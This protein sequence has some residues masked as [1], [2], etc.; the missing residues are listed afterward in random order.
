MKNANETR[1][2]PFEVITPEDL[3]IDDMND[4]FVDDLDEFKMLLNIGHMMLKGPRGVG[5]SMMFRYMQ[6]DCMCSGST[7]FSELEFLGFRIP[8]KNVS[9]PRLTEIQRLGNSYAAELIEEH[10]LVLSFAQIIFTELLE[11]KTIDSVLNNVDAESLY[12]Y[13]IKVFL[14]FFSEGNEQYN[15][16]HTFCGI[17]TAINE[18]LKTE[19]R[20]AANYVKRLAMPNSLNLEYTGSFLNYLEF[21]Y[22]LLRDLKTI[23]G[24]PESPVYLMIDDAH[25]LTL[26]QTQILNSWMAT[27]TAQKISIKIST[28]YSYKTYYTVTGGTIDTPHDYKQIDM[29]DIYTANAR[30]GSYRILVTKVLSKRFNKYNF[31]DV[32]PEVFFPPNYEQENKIKE[33]HDRYI[34]NYHGGEGH[35]ARPS[36]DA[37]RYATAD[38]IKSL[39]GQRKSGYTYSYAGFNQLVNI[40]SGVIRYFLDAAAKM[41]AEQEV[42]NEGTPVTCIKDSIQ[43]DVVTELARKFLKDEISDYSLEGHIN[44]APKEDFQKLTNLINAL[45]LLFS[46]IQFSDR[47]ERRVFSIAISDELTKETEEILALGVNY[48]YLHRSTIGRKERGYGRTWLYVL[49]RRLAPIWR[50]DPNSFAGYL[51]IQNKHLEAAMKNPK[52]ILRRLDEKSDIDNNNKPV[53]LELFDINNRIASDWID[54]IDEDKIDI[55]TESW[56]KSEDKEP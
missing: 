39:M 5:K 3:G 31:G 51:F 42:T 19:Y 32:L 30:K 54:D 46:T 47:S 55:I 48:A 50:L 11:L 21:F 22:P 26:L 4:L 45:G 52:L 49:N 2:N 9:F 53:Q 33:I 18:R 28:Q 7:G 14:P 34:E 8:M 29:S 56:I 20:V 37:Y 17:L 38:Y 40:S 25:C 15:I 36:D 35:G 27:R 41:Y 23:K 6:V 24:F 13:Y 12:D 43:S 1:R 10:L 16:E 44:A